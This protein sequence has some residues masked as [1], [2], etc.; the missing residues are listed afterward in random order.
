MSQF[1]DLHIHTYFSDSTSS[2]EEVV[3]H[4]KEQGLSAI[5]ITDHDIVDGIV[6]AM[7]AAKKYDIEVIPGV[8]LSSEINGRDVHV[9]GYFID[10][11]DTHLVKILKSMQGTRVERMKKMIEK[12]KSFGIEGIELEEVCALTNA[13]AVGRP[14]LAAIMIKK[15]V[16]KNTREAFDQYLAN[17]APAYV[18]KYDQTPFDAIALIKKSGGVAVLAHPMVT[19][20]DELIPQMVKA[21]LGGIEV[22]YPNNTNSVT[23]FYEKIAK[24]HDLAMT[25]GSDAHGDA[26]K[27]TFVGKLKIPYALVEKLKAK[28]Y[29]GKEK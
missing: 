2:P 29:A 21:G 20:V 11:T 9:L 13:D 14:H 10:Y 19:G 5:A 15:G 12:L 25:G 17:E 28:V 26:K 6:P 24:K 1:A 4:A 18:S 7:E 27:H 22:Y 3:E 16:V 23:A 8:E